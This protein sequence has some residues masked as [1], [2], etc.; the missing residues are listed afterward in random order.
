LCWAHHHLVHEGGWTIKGNA[1]QHLTFTSPYG[2]TLTTR[3]PPLHRETRK[4][5]E[6]TTGLDLGRPDAD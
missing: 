3:A 5:I 1:D 2:R 6:D 4:H